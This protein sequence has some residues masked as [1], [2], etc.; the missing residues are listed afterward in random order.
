[1]KYYIIAGEASGDLHGSNLMKSIKKLDHSTQFRVW[2]GDLMEKE[3]DGNL[4]KH[5]RNL[6]FVG[7][8]EVVANLRTILG[9]IKN[10]KKD[11]KAYQPDVLVL[12][13]YPGFNL[14]I[15]KW[16]KKQGLRVV[17]YISPQV[18]A[19]N[20]ARVHKMKKIIDKML[21][22]LPFEQEFYAKYDY[23]VDFVGHP[24]LDAIDTYP[25]STSFFQENQIEVERQI[26][27]LLP[28]SRGQEIR[29]IFSTMLPIIPLFPNYQFVLAAA[30]SIPK[31]VYQKYIADF[32]KTQSQKNQP[33]ID[34]KIVYN[35]TYQVLKNA[36]AAV[37]ASGTATLETGLF[38]VPQVVCY[39]GS[40]VSYQIAIRIVNITYISL[41]NL[42]MK[43]EV[44]KE[45]IQNDFTTN[46][47][48]RELKAIL[49]TSKRQEIASEYK[50]LRQ[51]LGGGGASD[52]AAK[53]I[54]EQGL[55]RQKE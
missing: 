41:V 32:N 37:V 5:Y 51:Q 48:S 39:K 8:T 27:A 49:E 42:I 34:L 4:V 35:Q 6:D 54:F 30:P 33:L 15:A 26:I 2:G 17:Y 20:S 1:M 29:N 55:L 46:N 11:I 7:F 25:D 52:R 40:W 10:C 22:I 36:H 50:K 28:G 13:D 24:L 14:R 21:V 31:E 45:L 12:I 44:V 19:W 16:A 43:K 9:N 53:A 38:Q 47:L 23:E 3:S 18:W